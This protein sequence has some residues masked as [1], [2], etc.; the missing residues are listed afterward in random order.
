MTSLFS[1]FAL[2]L[3]LVQSTSAAGG[4][5]VS[6]VPDEPERDKN[7]IQSQIDH[8]PKTIQGVP[9]MDVGRMSEFYSF[10]PASKVSVSVESLD[11]NTKARQLWQKLQ[12][13]RKPFVIDN[14]TAVQLLQVEKEC[15]R[16]S[17][18][19]YA[20]V[21]KYNELA[22][23]NQV[24]ATRVIYKKIRT[25]LDGASECLN[26]NRKFY[27]LA[28]VAINDSAQS[29]LM[30]RSLHTVNGYRLAQNSPVL[31]LMAYLLNHDYW[32]FFSSSQ[33]QVDV[34][35]GGSYLCEISKV[36]LNIDQAPFDLAASAFHE[37]SH[38]AKDKLGRSTLKAENLREQLIVEEVVAILSGALPQVELK[39]QLGFRGYLG[40]SSDWR[41]GFPNSL[42]FDFEAFEDG[43][44]LAT[45]YG[46]YF[47]RPYDQRFVLPGANVRIEALTSYTSVGSHY[48][49]EFFEYLK[50]H[51][52]V[53]SDR[54]KAQV[55]EI[56]DRVQKGYFPER[57]W[58]D[59]SL[60]SEHIAKDD[61]F[62]DWAQSIGSLYRVLLAGPESLAEYEAADAP[63]SQ[64]VRIY[65]RREGEFWAH[66]DL[67][68]FLIWLD[69][70]QENF[71]SK[72]RACDFYAKHADPDYL[73]SQLV[74]QFVND[75]VSQIV[76]TDKKNERAESQ[77]IKPG[78]KGIK[79]E[80]QGV[81]LEGQ[82]TRVYR[83]LRPCLHIK[84]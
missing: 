80:D 19:V 28:S 9:Y 62:L 58:I 59:P 78:D 73:G 27:L 74:I 84:L 32:Q 16:E 5:V 44:P 76:A 11:F 7:K 65:S 51:R 26:S 69:R 61:P 45:V 77:D 36:L 66:Y 33:V 54:A 70:Q 15:L 24:E 55:Y 12:F 67:E 20:S 64:S 71:Q 37:L 49:K 14:A 10:S 68:S 31:L 35:L 3:C 1:A 43:G 39:D 22:Q 75:E 30:K 72:S 56:F 63:T 17:H 25:N 83:V 46:S 34:K 52:Y 48:I 8:L 41:T 57:R 50:G 82:S 53:R 29:L 4:L 40:R 13:P 79:T 2:F 60:L 23:E 38:F 6:S 81:K 47:N 18:F 21:L 42:D